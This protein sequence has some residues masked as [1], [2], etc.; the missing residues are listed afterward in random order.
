MRFE[1][2]EHSTA[3]VIRDLVNQLQVRDIFVEEEPIEDIVKRIYLNGEV[4]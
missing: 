1:R 3:E 4:G 2:D